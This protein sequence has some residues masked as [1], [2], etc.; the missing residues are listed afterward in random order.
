MCRTLYNSGVVKSSPESCTTRFLLLLY[1]LK[2]VSLSV[3]L[4]LS[5]TRGLHHSSSV[6]PLFCRQRKLREVILFRS[7]PGT[8]RWVE[9]YSYPASTIRRRRRRHILP[10]SSSFFASFLLLPP[11]R[12]VLDHFHTSSPVELGDPRGVSG[13]TYAAQLCG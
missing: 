11:T 3:G 6:P 2:L 1:E 4:F 5:P 8:R 7:L 9:Y 12:L 10:S 13:V